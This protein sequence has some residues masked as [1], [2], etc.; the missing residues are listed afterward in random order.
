MHVAGNGEKVESRQQEDRKVSVYVA[1]NGE[2]GQSRQREDRKVSVHVAGNGEKVELR[3]REGRKASVHVAGNGEKGQSRQREGRKVSVYVA[4]NSEKVESHNG[5]FMGAIFVD[6]GGHSDI[7]R[8]KCCYLK[9]YEDRLMK[10]MRKVFKVMLGVAAVAVT[11][12]TGTKEVKAE[13]PNWFYVE[14]AKGC[15]EAKVYARGLGSEYEYTF[16]LRNWQDV[17][18]YDDISLSAPSRTKVYFRATENYTTPP[19]GDSFETKSG[20][21]RIGGDILTLLNPNPRQAQM[22][23]YAFQKLFNGC[24]G[25]VDASQL[26]LPNYVTPGCYYR[27]FNDC[28]NLKSAPNLPAT[29]LAD[30]CY[31]EMFYYC[32]SLTTAPNL[33]AM[34][35]ANDC[36][37]CMFGDCI[38]LTK[39]PKLPATELV[40]GCYSYM[41]KRCEKLN[42]VHVG[43]T[44][45]SGFAADSHPMDYWLDGTAS[46]G[47]L[48]CTQDLFDETDRMM[49]DYDVKPHDYLRYPEGWTYAVDKPVSGLESTGEDINFMA[50][51]MKLLREDDVKKKA[52]A[53]EIIDRDT[54]KS[55]APAHTVI[56]SEAATD[57][58]GL[59]DLKVHKPDEKTTANQ[60]FLAKTLVGPNVRILMTQNIYPRRDLSTTENGFAK[61]LTW[62]NL[63]KEQAG[64]VFAVI[65]NETDGAYVLNGTLDVNG[66]A[67]FNGFKL[68]SASTITICK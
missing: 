20:F 39:A 43:L 35:L 41:F 26:K 23:S 3:Q 15:S 2:N 60:E 29:E 65:Y 4:G 9:P 28:E 36:Y 34:T 30:A 51:L 55:D 8:Q 63:P 52:P 56:A 25:I 58:F 24:S 40:S 19:G 1:G 10:N 6:W 46:S 53:K 7:I 47:T 54:F 45:I 17:P 38:A 18:D 27:M 37:N 22:G 61:K 31:Q 62:N 44:S 64:P 5:V 68:R 32:I 13:E 48:Y 57:A 66:T 59:F 21:V 12:L 49:K 42:E 16:D 67:V 14:L 11:L 33:P 50:Y